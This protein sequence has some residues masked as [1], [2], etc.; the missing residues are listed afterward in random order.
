VI[1]KL[2]TNTIKLAIFKYNHFKLLCKLV[3]HRS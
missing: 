2:N 3:A 1:F